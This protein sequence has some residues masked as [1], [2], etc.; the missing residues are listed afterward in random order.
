MNRECKPSD[1]ELTRTIDEEV[2]CCKCKNC[3]KI[4]SS[5]TDGAT[6]LKLM[7]SKHNNDNNKD[8]T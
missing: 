8:A 3:G 7:E 6:A 4:T 5:Y 2:F 1:W